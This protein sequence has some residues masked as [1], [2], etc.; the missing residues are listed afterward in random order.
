MKT[1]WDT[2]QTGSRA[3][4]LIPE[5]MDLHMP[6]WRSRRDELNQAPLEAEAWG[7]EKRS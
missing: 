7:S 2:C 6:D 3:I 4:W 1:R 5:L